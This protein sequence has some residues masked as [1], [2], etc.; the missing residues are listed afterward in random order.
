LE[1]L[2]CSRQRRTEATKHEGSYREITPLYTKEVESLAGPLTKQLIN[3]VIDLIE[4]VPLE[5]IVVV[6][7]PENF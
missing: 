5:K 6:Q 7:L 4:P 3:Q 1:T 2:N